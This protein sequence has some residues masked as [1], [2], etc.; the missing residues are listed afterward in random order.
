MTPESR[1]IVTKRTGRPPNRTCD[2]CGQPK[3][4]RPAGDWRCKPCHNEV[5]KTRYKKEHPF[6]K[7]EYKATRLNGKP[8][9]R[10]CGGEK[11]WGGK[12]YRCPPCG[13]AYALR[14]RAKRA[15]EH[16]STRADRHTTD[17]RTADP[18]CQKCRAPRRWDGFQYRC[19]TCRVKA[20]Q[21]RSRGLG[22]RREKPLIELLAPDARLLHP[23]K[24]K[25]P[26]RPSWANAK[27]W[28]SGK[29]QLKDILWCVQ[30]HGVERLRKPKPAQ[31]KSAPAV[32]A[33]PI[34]ACAG[35]DNNNE[36]TGG[37]VVRSDQKQAG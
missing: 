35:A 31:R 21:L 36:L 15:E 29:V 30:T 5:V 25:P 7:S 27:T 17:P 18:I 10:K 12:Q 2:K 34:L 9:C 3:T 24:P 20:D 16:R 14:N 23:K 28:E 8:M 11:V 37:P 4:R 19:P 6:C 22:P 26:W 13:A 32:Q 1:E 33:G